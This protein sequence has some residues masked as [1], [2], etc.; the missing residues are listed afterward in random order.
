M[1]TVSGAILAVIIGV[2]I[3]TTVLYLVWNWI[4]PAVFSMRE[5]TLAQAWGLALLASLLRGDFKVSFEA[6]SH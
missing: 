5:V 3:N 6:T 4:G 2:L 1:K